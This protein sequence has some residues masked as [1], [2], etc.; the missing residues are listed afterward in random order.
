MARTSRALVQ[1][2]AARVASIPAPVGGW[3]ARDSIANM[4]PFD[5]YQLTN[6]FPGVS[7]LVLRGGSEDWATG[8]SG[9]VQTLVN[10]ST[11]TANK[12]FAWAGTSIYDATTQGAVGAAVK[13]GLTN[14]K[15]EHINVTTAAMP[16]LMP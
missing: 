2:T 5:A 12:L 3:N 13:T 7:N 6:Y 9:Q 10:Y 8:I 16:I 11:G 14:A 4:E 15:W 1:Q